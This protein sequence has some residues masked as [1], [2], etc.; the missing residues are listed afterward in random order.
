[1]LKSS[2]V[3]SLLFA[4]LLVLGLGTTALSSQAHANIRRPGGGR[5]FSIEPHLGFGYYNV[6]GALGVRFS[7]PI[8]QN[9]FIP[10]INN[11][12]FFNF[13]V[14]VYSN[15]KVFSM[16]IPLTLHWSFYFTRR[17]SMFFELGANIFLNSGLFSGGGFEFGINNWLTGALGLRYKFT[18][19]FALLLRVG[20]PYSSLGIE[21]F[22]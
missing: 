4:F 15:F 14:D 19:R 9:G 5:T 20:S 8:L 13:G 10:S 11:A 17:F 12:V 22:M 6:A 21:I 2:R 18:P 1:M 16:G 3:R 7:L